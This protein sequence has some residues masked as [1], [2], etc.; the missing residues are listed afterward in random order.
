MRGGAVAARRAH[1]PKVAGSSPA[2]ATRYKNPHGESRRVF[3]FVVTFLADFRARI[4]SL[5]NATAQ[6]L[7]ALI[8]SVRCLRSP[9]SG[10]SQ[11]LVRFRVGPERIIDARLPTVP[12]RLEGIDY[13]AVGTHVECDLPLVSRKRGPAAA[14]RTD[15]CRRP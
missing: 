8:L 4:G 13:I 5:V 12:G 15:R 9:V 2:P 1:N 14:L 3:Y 11:H 10:F 6:C 7:T